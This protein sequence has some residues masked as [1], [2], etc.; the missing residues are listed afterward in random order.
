MAS[1]KK[2]GESYSLIYNYTD[3]QGKR[4]QKWETYP[5][6]AD[7]KKRQKEVEYKDACG[8]LVVPRCT[9]LNELLDEYIKL[10]GKDKWAISTYEHN[11]ALINNY[12]RPYI[13]EAKLSDINAHYLEVYYQKLLKTPP[14]VNI[15]T[16]KRSSEFV[17]TSTIR[18]IHKILRSCF[19]QAVKWEILE[20]N[21]ADHATVPKHKSEKRQIWTAQDLMRA[22]E[23]CDDDQLK[24]AMNLS[25]AGSLRMGELLGLTWDCV[26]ISEEA[27]AEGRASI[28]IN[29]ELQRVNK[30]AM[31]S[32]DRKDIIRVFPE[33]S[34]MNKTVRVL[35]T[36]K[37]ESSIRRVY[38]PKTV[39]EMLIECKA[40][41]EELKEILGAEYQDYGLVMCSTFGT[42]ANEGRIR[43]EMKKLIREND[44]PDVVFH[45]LRH[46]SVTYKLKLNGGDIKSV[47]GDSGHSQVSMVTDV[48]S[49]IVDEDRK[50]NA[51]LLEEAFYEKKNLNPQMHEKN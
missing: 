39:A 37:T 26:D 32:V 29:K 10:Y 20:K 41:Q 7:A 45:S 38:I 22:M 9:D 40:K 11:L 27:I 18:D 16:G 8:C 3:H 46:S 25:F 36:P 17:S 4:K 43:K 12:I 21:P 13:G 42:P 35:K 23:V 14:V 31:E 19:K 28:Y 34:S 5:T 44:L 51:E 49:H 2:R 47:Q 1:I 50:K 33:K 48:Y 30:A 6:L 24:L 15:I